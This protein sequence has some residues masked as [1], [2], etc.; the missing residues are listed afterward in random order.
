MTRVNKT[1]NNHV[2]VP[3][4]LIAWGYD[5]AMLVQ[6]QAMFGSLGIYQLIATKYHEKHQRTSKRQKNSE[7]PTKGSSDNG[8]N[9]DI[10]RDEDRDDDCVQILQ[11]KCGLMFRFDS[12][13]LLVSV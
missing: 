9:E 1:K 4:R 2:F 8:K 3:A 11:S 6:M 7:K 5:V 10:K 12:Y 13:T